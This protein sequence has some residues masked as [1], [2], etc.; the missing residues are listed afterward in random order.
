MEKKG[1]VLGY[2]QVLAATTAYAACSMG[3]TMVNKALV[4]VYG[5]QENVALLAFQT[6]VGLVLLLI[7]RRVGWLQ[8]ENL[9]FSTLGKFLPLNACFIAMLFT[10]F[11]W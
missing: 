1:G 3:M 10:S 8:F 2:T 5:V 6:M 9:R 11:Q 4:R 7:G